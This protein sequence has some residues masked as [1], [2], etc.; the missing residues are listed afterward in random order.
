[1]TKMLSKSTEWN[2]LENFEDTDGKVHHVATTRMMFSK[3]PRVLMISF[4]SKS[5]IQI[6]EKHSH[7]RK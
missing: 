3:L 6:I 2:T 4:D 7:Q 5:H 1:M